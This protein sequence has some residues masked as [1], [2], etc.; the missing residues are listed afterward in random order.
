MECDDRSNVIHA[1]TRSFGWFLRV[2]D[3]I[4]RTASRFHRWAKRA[5]GFRHSVL[6]CVISP[7]NRWVFNP[8]V[9]VN[10]HFN[11]LVQFDICDFGFTFFDSKLRLIRHF[12]NPDIFHQRD[13]SVEIIFWFL[14][15]EL[16]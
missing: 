6:I 4:S 2:I 9:N 7:R 15:A 10:D 8:N 16:N 3:K 14:I 12:Q 5:A 1:K 11:G 13:D